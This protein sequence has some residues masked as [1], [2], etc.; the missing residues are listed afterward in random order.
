MCYNNRL[1]YSN[2]F[3]I[4]IDGGINDET[5]KE[6]LNA[7]GI[8]SGSYICMNKDFENRINNLRNNAIDIKD[9][10]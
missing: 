9:K 4:Y 8:I 7:D 2:N 1:D 5:I 6:V 3:E 10:I